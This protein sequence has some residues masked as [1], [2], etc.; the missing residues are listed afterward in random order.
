MMRSI[1]L[2]AV[3][4]AAISC[5]GSEAASVS[6]DAPQLPVG[7]WADA[8]AET[9]GETSDWS[10]K[11][12]LAD[13]NGDGLVD[14]LFANGGDYREPGEPVASKVFLNQG[15]GK[16]FLD[17]TAEIFGE[18]PMLC[19]V[20]KTADVDG[21]GNVDIFFGGVYQ[22]E[23]R[24]MLGDG[25]GGFSRAPLPEHSL[26]LGDA[27][28]GDVDFDGDLD[29]ALADWGPGNPMKNEGG[30]VRLWLNDGEG[31]FTPAAAGA[32]PDKKIRMSWDLELADVD[33]DYDLDLWVSSKLSEGGSLFVND[34]SGV[35]AD[36]TAGKLPQATNNYEYEPIDLNG[37]GFLDSFTINDGGLV[38][39]QRGMRK[40]NVFF[41]DGEGGFVLATAQ[42]F[43]DSENLGY[44]DN[45]IIA[46]DYDSDGDADILIGSL[47]GPDRLAINDGSGRF[48]VATEVVSGPETKGTLCVQ[49]A[50][51]NGDAR[52]DLV[53]AQGEVDGHE[54]EMVF[55][56]TENLPK[57]AAAPKIA[58]IGA[59][60]DGCVRA[61][62]YDNNS[63]TRPFDFQSVTAEVG[64][65]SLEMAWYGEHLWSAC[66]AEVSGA[67]ATIV[68]VDAAGN[69]SEATAELE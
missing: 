7:L 40:E 57:D 63:P 59:T 53:M 35:F 46:F 37:D 6:T 69:R 65:E 22:H 66:P 24:L 2:T 11:V 23:S 20:I 27:E 49:A 32:V 19:R 12:E 30:T 68:A 5:G 4:A 67:T 41:G 60:A 31:V 3:C 16:K 38:G 48:R 47:S 9:I 54:A 43:P 14:I 55:F 21:D 10:N 13:L 17:A 26:S 33:N 45:R 39:D 25:K 61:R 58:M 34:G 42:A 44:D 29:L 52:L 8:T 28:F 18:E 62:V 1:L 15:P 36:E 64:G 56:G 51:L 50:D